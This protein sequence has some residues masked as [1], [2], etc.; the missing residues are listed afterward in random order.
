MRSFVNCC[1]L[2]N[3]S[4]PCVLNVGKGEIEITVVEGGHCEVSVSE[5]R[6]N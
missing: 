6:E 3:R 4:N 1:T 2:G 5:K